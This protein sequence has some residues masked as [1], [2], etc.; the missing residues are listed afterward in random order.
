MSS[1]SNR[2][3]RSARAA[4][5]SQITAD[6][7]AAVWRST[8]AARRLELDSSTDPA[9]TVPSDVL[10]AITRM[11]D[12]KLIVEH[13]DLIHG[14]FTPAEFGTASARHLEAARALAKAVAERRVNGMEALRLVEVEVAKLRETNG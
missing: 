4:A 14:P 11:A 10:A 12:A 2:G 6:E 3:A 13:Q 9:V 8:S 5:T 1:T 7:R